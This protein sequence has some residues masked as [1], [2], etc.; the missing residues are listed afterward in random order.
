MYRYSG[1]L[2]SYACRL[3]LNVNNIKL[4]ITAKVLNII[5]ITR[6]VMPSLGCFFHQE[7]HIGTVFSIMIYSY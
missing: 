1:A 7:L 5:K 3:R 4:I 6:K 2:T